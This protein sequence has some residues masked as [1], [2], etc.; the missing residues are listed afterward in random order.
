MKTK[1]YLGILIG[2]LLFGA[3]AVGVIAG[4][5]LPK[6]DT[7]IK[8]EK[9]TGCQAKVI[10]DNHE[11]I[12]RFKPAGDIKVSRDKALKSFL[13]QDTLINKIDAKSINS[14]D[15]TSTICNGIETLGEG[16]ITLEMQK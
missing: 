14:I 4:G 2:V 5:I 3:F 1:I 7:T 8:L 13:Q 12:F 9:N 11:Y 10:I 15:I 6:S 16:K